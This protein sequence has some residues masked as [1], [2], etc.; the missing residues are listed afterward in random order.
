MKQ[1]PEQET[2]V[3]PLSTTEQIVSSTLF[4]SPTLNDWFNLDL[5]IRNS[6][7][8]SIFKGKLLSFVRPVQTN[9]NNIYDPK[10]LTF[11]TRLRLCLSHLNEHRF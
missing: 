1:T 11:P 4:F 9:I 7:S 10:G 2:T 6:E 8:I 5:N 3:Y